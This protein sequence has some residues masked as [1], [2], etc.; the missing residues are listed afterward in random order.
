M[1]CLLFGTRASA[2]LFLPTIL[3]LGLHPIEA[4]NISELIPLVLDK[5][6]VYWIFTVIENQWIK[7]VLIE[8]HDKVIPL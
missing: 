2:T 6:I 4:L 5:L 7:F 1:A 8:L 3:V